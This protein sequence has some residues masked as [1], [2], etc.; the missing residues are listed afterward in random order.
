MA[1][2]IPFEDARARLTGRRIVGE[3]SHLSNLD[4]QAALAELEAI[5]KSHAWNPLAA[6]MRQTHFPPVRAALARHFAGE[7]TALMSSRNP[8]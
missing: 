2:V 6:W 4:R 5:V 3:L 7:Q 8:T 1:R